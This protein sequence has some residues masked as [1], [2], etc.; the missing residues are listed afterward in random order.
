MCEDGDSAGVQRE[1]EQG[2]KY[3]WQQVEVLGEFCTDFSMPSEVQTRVGV[4]EEYLQ[5]LKDGRKNA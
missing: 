1:L 2:L 4:Y 5:M 3:L